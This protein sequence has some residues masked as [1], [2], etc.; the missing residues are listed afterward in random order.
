[1]ILEFE[2]IFSKSISTNLLCRTYFITT[3]NKIQELLPKSYI[4]LCDKIINIFSANG[5]FYRVNGVIYYDYMAF[6]I[7]ISVIKIP[8]Q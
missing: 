4:S 1:M 5:Y 7:T 2:T 8:L 6:G 3:E